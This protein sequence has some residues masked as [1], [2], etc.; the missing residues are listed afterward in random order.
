M[1]KAEL[2]SSSNKLDPGTCSLWPYFYGASTSFLNRVGWR[3]NTAIPIFS[4]EETDS[5]GGA[6]PFGL[7]SEPDSPRKSLPSLEPAA[8]ATSALIIL[9]WD[10]RF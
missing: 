3:K 6:E 7:L 4:A 8:H 5:W 10:P 1:E 9:Y 2:E